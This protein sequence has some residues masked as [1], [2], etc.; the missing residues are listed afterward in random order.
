MDPYGNGGYGDEYGRYGGGY[1]ADY[2]GGY[3]DEF[4]GRGLERFP[5]RGPTDVRDFIN[6]IVAVPTARRTK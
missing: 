1:G 6:F 2:P 4:E 3:G 5:D